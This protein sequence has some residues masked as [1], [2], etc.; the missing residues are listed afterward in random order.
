M[1]RNAERKFTTAE[2]KFTTAECTFTTAECTFTAAEHKP[3][4]IFLYN[5]YYYPFI[6]TTSIITLS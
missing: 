5:H 1:F 4:T 3:N 6:L 2:C